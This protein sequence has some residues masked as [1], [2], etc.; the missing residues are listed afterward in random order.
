MNLNWPR[1]FQYVC[2]AFNYMPCK[3]FF[4]FGT[5][6]T[7]VRD[8]GKFAKNDDIDVGVYF[9]DF[10]PVYIKNWCSANGFDVRRTI[11][12]DI[13]KKPLYYSI[14]PKPDIAIVT[15]KFH[16]DVFAWMKYKNYYWHTYDVKI[17]NPKHGIPNKYIFKGVP[18]YALQKLTNIDGIAGTMFSGFVPLKYGTLLDIWYPNWIE[19]REEVSHTKWAL[20]VHSCKDIYSGKA[21]INEQSSDNDSLFSGRI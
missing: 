4:C 8:K 1:I 7:L 15:G 10:E 5:M 3:W 20:N 2:T 12:D 11:I 19:R 9:E 16:L 21:Q 14:V 13:T 17:E 18:E 6:L